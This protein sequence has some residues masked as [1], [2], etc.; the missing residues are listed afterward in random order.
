MSGGPYDIDV[1][2]PNDV[3]LAGSYM[4]SL[5]PDTYTW[6]MARWNGTK[7]T[8][9]PAP[10]RIPPYSSYS[11]ILEATSGGVWHAEANRISRWDGS[12]WTTV[13]MLDK[14]VKE[15]HSFTEDNALATTDDGLWKWDG[16]SWQRLPGEWPAAAQIT[17]PDSAWYADTDGL[18]TWNGTSWNT[19]PYS[20]GWQD[21]ETAIPISESDGLWV[22]LKRQNG[23][24]VL[25]RWKD[26]A[27]TSYADT[28]SHVKQ[29]IVDDAGR[30]WA[31]DRITR[32]MPLG[33]GQAPEHKG[34]LLRLNADG[35]GWEPV[36]SVPEAYYRMIKL[37]GSDRLYAYG[38][39]YWNGTDHITTNASP[40]P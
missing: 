34:K 8:K 20:E 10:T 32:Y 4:S 1:V 5:N 29:V 33:S 23:N 15:L 14:A 25:S 22:Y 11:S 30:V 38:Y 37:P 26:G 9:I 18:R 7:W 17:G 19:V 36:S 12:S 31:V 35:R 24:E 6:Y 28:P 27:W 3:W 16:A 21:P 39:N 13:A 40:L 2:S